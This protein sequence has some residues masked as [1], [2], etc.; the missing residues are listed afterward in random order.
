MRYAEIDFVDSGRC[1]EGLGEVD[2]SNFAG[3]LTCWTKLTIYFK[4]DRLRW[5]A[6]IEVSAMAIAAKETNVVMA[7]SA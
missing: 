3:F 1:A 6:T 2:Q 7:P 5:M 4:P